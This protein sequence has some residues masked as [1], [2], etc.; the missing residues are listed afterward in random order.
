MENSWSRSRYI[1]VTAEQY[2]A[3]FIGAKVSSSR[4]DIEV[5]WHEQIIG[6]FLSTQSSLAEGSAQDTNSGLTK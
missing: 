1:V 2:F 4:I 6:K 3:V 5:Q